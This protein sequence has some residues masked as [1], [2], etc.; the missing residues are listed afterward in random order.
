MLHAKLPATNYLQRKQEQKKDE[1]QSV[2]QPDPSRD[3]LAV[4]HE[5]N[6]QT[7]E[8]LKEMIKLLNGQDRQDKYFNNHHETKAGAKIGFFIG[9]RRTTPP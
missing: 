9:R 3:W 1:P 8:L 6:V 2:Q 7:H 4:L 5:D